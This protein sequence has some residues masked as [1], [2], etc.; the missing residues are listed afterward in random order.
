MARRSTSLFRREAGRQ[1]WKGS[2]KNAAPQ[3][4]D[5]SLEDSANLHNPDVVVAGIVEGLQED[6]TRFA[7]I[8]N[9]LKR[10]N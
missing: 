9:D 4:E 7:K 8:T 5:E 10:P 3:S 2:C 1:S 6:L